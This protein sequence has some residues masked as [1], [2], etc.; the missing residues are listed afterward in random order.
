MY[1]EAGVITKNGWLQIPHC[2]QWH[3]PVNHMAG[4]AISTKRPWLAS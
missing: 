2:G 4:N 1:N 3:P